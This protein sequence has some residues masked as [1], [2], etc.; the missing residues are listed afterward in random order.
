MQQ[1]LQQRLQ[2]QHLR[3]VKVGITATTVVINLHHHHHHHHHRQHLCKK[4][5]Q[6]EPMLLCPV[7]QLPIWVFDDDNNDEDDNLDQTYGP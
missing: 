3:R 4:E 6:V 2:Q 7:M 5:C 1:R